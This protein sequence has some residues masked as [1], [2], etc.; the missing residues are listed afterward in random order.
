[1]LP[2]VPATEFGWVVKC[3]FFVWPWGEPLGDMKRGPNQR[4][5]RVEPMKD[6]VGPDKGFL[7]VDPLRG[8]PSVSS[9]RCGE[10]SEIS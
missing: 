6:L 7:S 3:P 1:M 10:A 5:C 8:R 9:G 2:L 4:A